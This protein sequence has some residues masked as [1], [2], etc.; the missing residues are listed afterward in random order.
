MIQDISI[1]NRKIYSEVYAI[2]DMIGEYYIKKLPENI[3]Q[4]ILKL[5]QQDYNPKYTKDKSLK[6][7]HVS[8]D[9][10]S[11]IAFFHLSYWCES[12][13]EKNNL[14]K[15]IKEN[16]IKNRNINI[17]DQVKKNDKSINEDKTNEPISLNKS[18]LSENSIEI[19]ENILPVNVE[20]DNFI[21]RIF[22]KLKSFFIKKLY[23]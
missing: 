2:L 23:K 1:Q 7:Q 16:E 8:R 13:E 9:A 21:K 19:S 12:S 15:I 5:K 6:M 17:F 22:K 14:K 10:I 4:N 20:K 3:Y 11:I 18:E